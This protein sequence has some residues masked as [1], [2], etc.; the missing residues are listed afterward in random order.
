MYVQC[1]LYVVNVHFEKQN[2]CSIERPPS[3]DIASL[4]A[5]IQLDD[6]SSEDSAVD[7]HKSANS[8]E[9]FKYPD[10]YHY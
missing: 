7:E 2:V 6:A 10:L 4:A 1:P 9:V 5:N 8:A 3:Y